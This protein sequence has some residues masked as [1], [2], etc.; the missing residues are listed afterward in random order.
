LGLADGD[1]ITLG[2]RDCSVQR[3]HK[4]VVEETPLPGVGADLRERML[5]GAIQAA[6]AVGYRN[7]G[8]VECLVDPATQEY[9]FLEMNTR[10]Q[11]EHPVTELV[12][13]VGLVA[14]QF[15]VAARQLPSRDLSAVEPGGHA[16]EMWVYAE[17]PRRFLPS[18]GSISV[19]DEP[20]GEGVR[21]DSGYE[22]GS[23]VTPHYDP[24]WPSC[25]SQC[26]PIQYDTGVI[27][28]MRR[29]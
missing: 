23:V 12:T 1:V 3:R 29:K 25:H 19:W 27:A 15:R 28:L 5:A 9:V 20:V 22:A 14:E 7:A 10:L 26:V 11:V 2:E 17:D 16:I 21:A 8:T 18:P 6:K 13:G 4:E 24:C